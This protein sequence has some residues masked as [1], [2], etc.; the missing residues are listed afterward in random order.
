MTARCVNQSQCWCHLRRWQDWVRSRFGGMKLDVFHGPT[1]RLGTEKIP[2]F[3][4]NHINLICYLSGVCV[5]GGGAF[6]LRNFVAWNQSHS[7]SFLPG[8]EKPPQRLAKKE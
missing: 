2:V 5:Y 1:P 4:N 8:I 3:A 7:L 6:M